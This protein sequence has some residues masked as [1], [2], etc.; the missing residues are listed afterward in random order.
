MLH[1][2]ERQ[3]K[4]IRLHICHRAGGSEMGWIGLC[5]ICFLPDKNDSLLNMVIN[6][7]GSQFLLKSHAFA[8]KM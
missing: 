6:S 3:A 5:W 1:I 7:R 8:L 4:A 2:G